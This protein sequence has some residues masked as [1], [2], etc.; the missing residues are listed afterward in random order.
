VGM[1]CSFKSYTTCDMQL[2][3]MTSM[4]L[5]ILLNTFYAYFFYEDGH[6]QYSCSHTELLFE[7]AAQ[8]GPMVV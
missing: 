6:K 1:A 8:E 7:I 3:S 5:P 2:V 4:P